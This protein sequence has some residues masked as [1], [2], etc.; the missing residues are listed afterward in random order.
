M[1]RWQGNADLWP[2]LPREPALRPAG[3][4]NRVPPIVKKRGD[5]LERRP[6]AGIARERENSAYDTAPCQRECRTPPSTGCRDGSPLPLPRAA[7]FRDGRGV[8][9]DP[10]MW[11]SP[12]GGL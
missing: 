8:E 11:V 4:R 10:I 6:P 1:A 3:P 9:E 7:P 2:A 12:G 5:G